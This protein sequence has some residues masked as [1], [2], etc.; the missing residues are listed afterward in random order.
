[1]DA[2][3]THDPSNPFD[4]MGTRY[5][6][7]SMNAHIHLMERS[8]RYEAKAEPRVE[9]RLREV[10][11]IC[12]DVMIVD[13]PGCMNEFFTPDWRPLAFGDSFGHDAETTYLLLETARALGDQEAEKTWRTTRSLT[14]HA[15]ALGWTKSGAGS[16]RRGTVWGRVRIEPGKILVAQAEGL[17]PCC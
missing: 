17:T 9:A 1:M 13:P 11:R 6:F 2:T 8:R 15:L 12:R 5:G 14:D 16:S 10:F 7:K 4:Q 3:R